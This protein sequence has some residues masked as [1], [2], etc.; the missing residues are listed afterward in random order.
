MGGGAGEG[1]G[2]VVGLVEELVE[3][4]AAERRRLAP[5]RSKARLGP[6]EAGVVRTKSLEALLYQNRYLHFAN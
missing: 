6:W 5:R 2:G 3:E 1:R 4:V